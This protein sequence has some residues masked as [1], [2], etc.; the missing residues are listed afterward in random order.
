[1]GIDFPRADVRNIFYL[2]YTLLGEEFEIEG[3]VWPVVPEDYELAKAFTTLV[4]TLLEQG[5]IKPHPAD[6]R[7]GL[8]NIPKG[9]QELKDGKVSGV[10]VVYVIDE[11]GQ[12]S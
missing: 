5:K 4:E 6:V 9:M 7:Y 8:E 10:K 12:K 11:T 2:G 1:M 3:E